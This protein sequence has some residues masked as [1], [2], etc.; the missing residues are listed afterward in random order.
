MPGHLFEGNPVDEDTK[1]RVTDTPVHHSVKAAGST[2]SS[3][4]AGGDRW[5]HLRAGILEISQSDR[6]RL[7]SESAVVCPGAPAINAYSGSNQP[8]HSR[9]IIVCQPFD[10]RLSDA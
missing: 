10:H 1:R 7:E 2:H 9:V 8:L 6:W 5:D 4:G 3:L